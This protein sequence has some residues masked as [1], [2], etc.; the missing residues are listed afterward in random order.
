MIAAAAFDLGVISRNVRIAWKGHDILRN[1]TDRRH[2][3]VDRGLSSVKFNNSVD[4]SSR[5]T[6]SY[7][8]FCARYGFPGSSAGGRCCSAGKKQKVYKPGD[9]GRRG[10]Q[11]ENS[12]Q[13]Q[14]RPRFRSGCRDA[15]VDI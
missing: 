5:T 7:Q 13:G 12:K 1:A 4:H 6:L 10:E 3:A 14:R 11:K 15:A 8:R 2:V 9:C